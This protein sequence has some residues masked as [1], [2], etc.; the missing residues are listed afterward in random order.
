M[1]ARELVEAA[2]GRTPVGVGDRLE[3]LRRIQSGVGRWG[4]ASAHIPLETAD[5]AESHRA[6][7]LPAAAA[8][9]EERNSAEARLVASAMRS[10]EAAEA[11]LAPGD[12]PAAT[13]SPA[14]TPG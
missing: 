4:A 5:K 7:D 11:L 6:Q 8:L 1:V 2:S 14:E 3:A 10:L 9:R 12:N 13:G